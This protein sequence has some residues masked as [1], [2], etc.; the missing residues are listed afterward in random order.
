[1]N[2]FTR[3]GNKVFDIYDSSKKLFQFFLALFFFTVEKFNLIA[4]A[5]WKSQRRQVLLFVKLRKKK[6]M[7]GSTIFI[8]HYW[9]ISFTIFFS[10][11]VICFNSSISLFFYYYHISLSHLSVYH[12]YQFEAFAKFITFLLNICKTPSICQLIFDFA[13]LFLLIY[14][15]HYFSWQLKYL[16][17]RCVE[18]EF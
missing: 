1:M 8:I 4:N 13:S 3:K 18:N 12:I 10:T 11:T 9:L 6:T 16:N 15:D 2:I 14:I 7:H 5:N 17:G